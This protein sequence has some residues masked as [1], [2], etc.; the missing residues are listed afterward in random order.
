[1]IDGSKPDA[2]KSV[3]DIEIFDSV[4]APDELH[5]RR[6]RV[7]IVLAGVFL[8]AMALLNVVGI[9]RFIHIGPL[10]LAVGVLPY[11]LTF[12]CTDFISEFYGRRRA[13]FVVAVGL[14]INVLVFVTLWL[15]AA[16]P[17]VD[18]TLQP[19]WQTIPLGGPLTLPNGVTVEGDIELF[20]IIYGCMRGAVL[21]SMVAYMAAQFCD[22]YLFHFW[23]RL[24]KGR[25][26]WLRNNGSTM[27]S[28][29][30]DATA[31]ISITFGAQYL[32]GEM[33]LST[34]A[35]LIGDNYLFKLSIAAF[36][37]IP[38]YIGVRI[39]GRY[40]RIDPSLTRD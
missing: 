35:S 34:M 33:K 3:E 40:L 19:P 12:L 26:L 23:K 39:L 28:Q 30:V 21:A 9:T 29:L 36:D 14:L 5:E 6:E 16:A 22:V 10:A 32:A 17:A 11:P 31:V 1:M 2:P 38:F 24:T 4:H 13:N 7:F 18:P 37:T 25:H 15:G 27:V 20:H 8:G